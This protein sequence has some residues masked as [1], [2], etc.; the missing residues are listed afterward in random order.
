MALR[1]LLG[2]KWRDGLKGEVMAKVWERS[3]EGLHEDQDKRPDLRH[4]IQVKSINLV[5]KSV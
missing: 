3:D 2:L 5:N 1:A 4:I